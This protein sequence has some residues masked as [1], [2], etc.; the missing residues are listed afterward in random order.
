MGS[1][2]A[3]EKRFEEEGEPTEDL[4]RAGR[5]VDYEMQRAVP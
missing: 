2:L 3:S 1:K 5:E 4:R